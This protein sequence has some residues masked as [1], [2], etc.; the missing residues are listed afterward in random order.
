MNR[1]A[2]LRG[3]G[4]LLLAAIA[5]G[6]LFPVAI[7]ALPVLDP[8][9]MTAIRYGLTAIVFVGLLVLTEGPQALKMEGRGLRAALLGATGF[10]GLGILVFVGLQHSRAEHGAIM[11]A[12]Q[13]LIAAVVAWLLRGVRP[14][15]ATLAFLGIALA[16]VLLVVTKGRASGLFG[17]GTGLGDL[18]MFLGAVSWV[19]YTLGAADFPSWSPLRYTAITCVLSLPAIFGITAIAS[20]TGYVSTPSLSDVESVGWQLAYMIVIASVVG[21]LAWNAGNKLLGVTNGMLF[22]NFVPV[23]VFAIRIAQGHHFQ[24]I[25]FVGAALVIGALIGNNVVLGRSAA[26]A[27]PVGKGVGR[28]PLPAYARA[29][30]PAGCR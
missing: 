5:W 22:I 11:M 1:V 13:P 6:A 3:A 8:F 29:I 12:T 16:G 7:I 18:M 23:T 4:L 9:H 15:R 21:V 28:S 26:S 24:P 10:A 27:Q 14:P 19:I 2:P 17:D 25:E 20:A 30:K